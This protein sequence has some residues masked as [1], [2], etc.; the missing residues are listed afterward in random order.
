VATAARALP[1]RGDPPVADIGTARLEGLAGTASTPL[2]EGE[3]A[4]SLSPCP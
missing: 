2:S 4:G 1:L 3:S